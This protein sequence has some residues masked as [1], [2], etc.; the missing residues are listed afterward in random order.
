MY[1]QVFANGLQ[2]VQLF[3]TFQKQNSPSFYFQPKHFDVAINC[4][5]LF[6]IHYWSQKYIPL[7][8]H[9]VDA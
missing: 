4:F 5:K 6:D 8:M 2:F 7:I 9:M 3:E 1:Y